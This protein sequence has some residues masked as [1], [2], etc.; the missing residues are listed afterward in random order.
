MKL[1]VGMYVR[2]KDGHVDKII[3]INNNLLNGRIIQVKNGELDCCMGYTVF[4]D[5]FPPS[6]YTKASFNII[7]LFEEKDLVEIEFYSL[8]AEK[9]IT[10]LFEV[11]FKENNH[12]TFVNAHC[13][14][15]ILNGIWS[16]EDASLEPIFKSIVTREQFEDAKY[17]IGDE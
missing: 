13:Q 16:N 10:R 4:T 17:R 14:L 6:H 2:T 3:K 11:D 5:L 12:I 9:R 15:Y 1:E 7:D 8:R